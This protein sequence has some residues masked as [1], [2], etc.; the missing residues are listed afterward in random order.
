[1]I[2]QGDEGDGH[3]SGMSH[4]SS[5]SQTVDMPDAKETSICEAKIELDNAGYNIN[6]DRSIELRFIAI[7]TVLMLESKTVEIIDKIVDLAR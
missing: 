4:I 6:S 2:Y 3:I 1:M 7:L 5:F